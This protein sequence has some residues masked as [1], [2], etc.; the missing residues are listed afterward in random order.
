MATQININCDMG[1]GFG[2]WTL[3]DDAG[4]LPLVPTANIATGF[5][6][7]DPTIMRRVVGLAKEVGAEIG[8]HVALPDL[9]GFGRRRIDVSPQELQDY[10]TYQIGALGAFARAAGGELT[11]VK[12]HGILYS[13]AGQ[14]PAIGQA[15]LTAVRDYDRNLIVIVGGTETPAIGE[16]LGVRTLAEAYCD[17][18]YHPNGYP[19]VERH[20]RAWDPEE[21]ARRA[22]RI[23]LDQEGT[24]VDGTPLKLDMRTMCIHGDAANAV[25]VATLVRQRLAEAG[26]EVVP[27]QAVA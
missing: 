11:H 23:A 16:E 3:G 27:L 4:I 22:V 10:V 25:E 5:H 7:G 13:M 19:V 12:P 2:R 26:V 20:K 15:L 17:L 21:V 24:A 8:A 14:D 6:A 18:D 1:E 9:L